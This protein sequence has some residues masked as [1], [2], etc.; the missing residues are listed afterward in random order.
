MSKI[1]IAMIA[2]FALMVFPGAGI[3]SLLSN[4]LGGGVAE[5]FLYPIYGGIILL[6]GLIVGCTVI[7]LEEIKALKEEINRVSNK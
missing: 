6:A 3:W 4:V 5:S 1:L 7:I 2:M